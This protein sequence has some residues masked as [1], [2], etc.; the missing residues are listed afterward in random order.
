MTQPERIAS[1]KRHKR[2][3]MANGAALQNDA[4]SFAFNWSS[5]ARSFL[6]CEAVAYF[7]AKANYTSTGKVLSQRSN[8]GSDLQL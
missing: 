8:R 1:L 3:A 5:D 7:P 4:A 2:I 6:A